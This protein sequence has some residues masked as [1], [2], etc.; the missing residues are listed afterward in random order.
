MELVSGCICGIVNSYYR[1]V[2]YKTSDAMWHTV[3]VLLTS[4]VEIN[5]GIIVGCMPALKPFIQTN[6]VKSLQLLSFSHIRSRLH[7]FRSQSYIQP[8]SPISTT[9]L[10]RFDSNPDENRD[11]DRRC[12]TE[13][14]IVWESGHGFKLA[15]GFLSKVLLGTIPLS[16]RNCILRESNLF[17]SEISNV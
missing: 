6:L 8:Q 10:Q 13:D 11:N 15:T 4:L 2:L 7:M 3:P 12:Q 9:D 14:T 16:S 1:V 5:V 17:R